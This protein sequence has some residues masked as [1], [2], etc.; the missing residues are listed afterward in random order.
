MLI[1]MVC[2]DEF[3]K[4]FDFRR[5]WSWLKRA[6]IYPEVIISFLII[7]IESMGIES[8]EFCESLLITYGCLVFLEPLYS[9]V[10]L[11]GILLLTIERISL[12]VSDVNIFNLFPLS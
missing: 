12:W 10:Y 2:V 8:Q 6:V 9:L 7:R 3:P 11:F 4:R 1:K 5:I